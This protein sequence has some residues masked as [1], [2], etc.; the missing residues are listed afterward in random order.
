MCCH[1]LYCNCLYSHTSPFPSDRCCSVK[2]SE[3]WESKSNSDLDCSPGPRSLS[4]YQVQYRITGATGWG[5]QVTVQ[6]NSTSTLLPKLYG[7]T[8][9]DV[10]VRALSTIENGEWSAVQTERTYFDGEFPHFFCLLLQRL[11]QYS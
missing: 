2:G 8:K 5:D 6:P 3:K 1:L 11:S 9:Y 4:Q 7:V 10:R